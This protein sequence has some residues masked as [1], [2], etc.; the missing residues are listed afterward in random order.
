MILLKRKLQRTL[1][2]WSMRRHFRH[3]GKDPDIDPSLYYENPEKIVINDN[4]QIRKGV[5]L[6][7]RS[8]KDVGICIDDGTHIK[9]YV[10]IDAYGGS[11]LLGKEVRIGHHTVLAGHGSLVFEDYSGISGLSYVIAADH[12]FEDLTK[13]VVEQ[14]ETKKGIKI[15][16]YAWIGC[17]SVILDGVTI[18]RHSVVGAGSVVRKNIPGYCVAYG[19]PA[20]P[21]RF[22]KNK[23][24]FL[25]ST[26]N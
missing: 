12:K 3:V 6:M 1:K 2:I 21:R 9:E 5:V 25:E 24:Q 4:V 20:E 19:A 17:G 18:G 26:Q 7:G 11:V 10:Y 8:S 22:L 13:P 14:S 15:K 23:A 16:E